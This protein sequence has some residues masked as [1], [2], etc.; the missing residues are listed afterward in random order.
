MTVVQKQ[1]LKC[2]DGSSKQIKHLARVVRK[3]DN[4]V[5]HRINHY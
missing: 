1:L 3:V 2:V 4:A 5:T